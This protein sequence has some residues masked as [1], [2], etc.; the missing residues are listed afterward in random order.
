MAG[1][2][3]CWVG[4]DRPKIAE[5]ECIMKIIFDKKVVAVTL[6]SISLCAN[7]SRLNDYLVLSEPSY[8]LLGLLGCGAMA[9]RRL[10]QI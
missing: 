3:I 5:K 10:R 4:A 8:L 6:V 1:H 2:K 9:L 7:A